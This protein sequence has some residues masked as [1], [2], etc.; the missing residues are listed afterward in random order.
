MTVAVSSADAGADILAMAEVRIC[1]H[2]VELSE[3][4]CVLGRASRESSSD[5]R[6]P[7]GH[8][9]RG[10]ITFAENAPRHGLVLRRSV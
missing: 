10:F 6:A 2:A 5:G 1:L 9:E 4:N 3:K 7:A 8:P